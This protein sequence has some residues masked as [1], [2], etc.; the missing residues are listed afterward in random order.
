M[1]L[2]APLKVK[3]A[4]SPLLSRQIPAK[5]GQV[6]PKTPLATIATTTAKTPLP[7]FNAEQLENVAEDV[8]SPAAAKARTTLVNSSFVP[9]IRTPVSALRKT[10]HIPLQR[11]VLLTA[12]ECLFTRGR[13]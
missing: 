10:P 2:T 4:V 3:V 12:G 11:A 13:E 9:N 1:W 5:T 8:S 7:N 6:P